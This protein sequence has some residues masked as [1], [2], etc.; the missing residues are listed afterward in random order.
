MRATRVLQATC[1]VLLCCGL[2]FLAALFLGGASAGQ[3]GAV[4]SIAQPSAAPTPTCP[5]T[6][7]PAAVAV[8]PVDSPT[9]LFYQVVTATQYTCSYVNV[10]A[11]SGL[12]TAP[13]S[14]SL[15]LV[16]VA[17]LPNTTHHLQVTGCVPG[18]WFGGCFYP[19]YC[20]DT[21]QDYNGDPLIIVQQCDA[22]F[23][24]HLPIV[25]RGRSP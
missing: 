13:C 10:S 7:T 22:C 4:T 18:S 6:G 21:H 3:G 14:H 17:L 9:D 5:P 2:A 1:I 25:L 8:A 15:A 19:G 11:E 16:K 20:V 12:F 24:H 23:Q